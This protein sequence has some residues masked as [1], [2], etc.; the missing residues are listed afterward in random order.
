[1]ATTATILAI[2][3]Y[4]PALAPHM[5]FPAESYADCPAGHVIPSEF[6]AD[7]LLTRSLVAE[8]TAALGVDYLDP[9]RCTIDQRRIDYKALATLEGVDRGAL[10]DLI[11][12]LRAFAAAGYRLFLRVDR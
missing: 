8:V 7:V 9:V 11:E 6:G 12:K 1:M 10:A 4:T 2:G 3:R 5:E